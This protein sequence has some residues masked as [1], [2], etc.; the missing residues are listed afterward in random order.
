MHRSLETTNETYSIPKHKFS[1]DI[2]IQFLIREDINQYP[3][4]Q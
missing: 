3:K 2:L 4:N 1:S